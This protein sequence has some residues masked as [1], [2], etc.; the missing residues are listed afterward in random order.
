METVALD[1]VLASKIQMKIF[2]SI[3]RDIFKYAAGA[4]IAL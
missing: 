3:E 2:Q 1:T 4:F